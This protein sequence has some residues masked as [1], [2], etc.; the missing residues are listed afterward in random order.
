MDLSRIS[1]SSAERKFRME[2]GLCLACGQT[3]HIA[4]DH[5]RKIDLVPMPKRPTNQWISRDGNDYKQFPTF[6]THDLHSTKYLTPETQP[7]LIP[8]MY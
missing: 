1:I 5:Y 4:I 3:G 7:L 8:M 2:N 6:N